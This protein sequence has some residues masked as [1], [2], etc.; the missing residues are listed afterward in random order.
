M[1]LRK[2][3]L[4]KL[5]FSCKNAS[6]LLEKQEHFKLGKVERVKLAMHKS[7]CSA[8]RKFEKK[9]KEFGDALSIALK[10]EEN[11]KKGKK[12]LSEVTKSRIKL[13]FQK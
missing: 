2:E 9:N 7:V 6:A 8:C 4:R 13:K 5:I 1:S 10:E 11:S 12:S 3:M